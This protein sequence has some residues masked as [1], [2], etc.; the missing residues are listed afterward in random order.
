MTL[1]SDFGT[2][3]GTISG[4]SFGIGT[5]KGEGHAFYENNNLRYL[6]TKGIGNSQASSTESV[7]GQ[8]E[9]VGNEA[10]VNFSVIGAMTGSLSL[11]H[12]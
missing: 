1:V 6:V 3:V 4:T 8:T 10:K 5:E 2:S 9:T 7:S 12:I 11:I